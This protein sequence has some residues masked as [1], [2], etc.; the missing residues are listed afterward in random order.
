MVQL[1][2]VSWKIWKK[3]V[4][5]YFTK[6]LKFRWCAR[7]DQRWRATLIRLDEKVSMVERKATSP[8]A[9]LSKRD[10]AHEKTVRIPTKRWVESSHKRYIWAATEERSNVPSTTEIDK[11]FKVF[12][13]FNIYKR[14][15]LSD[16]A[17]W[18]A[19]SEDCQ[20]K[21]RSLLEA[22]SF[23]QTDRTVWE[24]TLKLLFNLAASL[25]SPADSERGHNQQ[26]DSTVCKLCELSK[27][28]NPLTL[29][30]R[31]RRRKS[32]SSFLKV[33]SQNKAKNFL[34]SLSHATCKD[35]CDL[36]ENSF[37]QSRDA[38]LTS[39]TAGQVC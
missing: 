1:F 11:T 26:E 18:L 19:W 28:Q 20:E 6:A 4:G 25:S 13:F 8:L 10:V 29:F 16:S 12:K 33:V 34:T 27:W 15:F 32:T 9:E 35:L 17:Y 24:S 7:T 37:S 31:R 2:C 3:S 30:H 5:D 14:S 38:P 39:N 36:F 21:F 23:I 22:R